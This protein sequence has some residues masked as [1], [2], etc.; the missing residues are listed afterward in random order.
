MVYW[1]NDFQGLCSRSS[2]FSK[3]YLEAYGTDLALRFSE[4]FVTTQRP[5]EKNLS[6]MMALYS[7]ADGLQTLMLVLNTLIVNISKSFVASTPSRF[8]CSSLVT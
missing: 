2:S 3:R 1:L 5:T 8:K 4:A 7:L 6:V